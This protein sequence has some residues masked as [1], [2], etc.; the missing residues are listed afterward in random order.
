MTLTVED[1]IGKR[2]IVSVRNISETGESFDEY[3]GIIDTVSDVLS[4]KVEGGSDKEFKTLP[5]DLTDFELT[6]HDVI[7]QL[8]DNDPISG[9]DFEIYWTRY[10][11]EAVHKKYGNQNDEI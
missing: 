3:W 1:V 9:V 4:I 7:Y 10:E 11:T 8:K 5:P 2:A 6:T